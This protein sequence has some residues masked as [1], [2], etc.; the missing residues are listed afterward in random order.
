MVVVGVFPLTLFISVPFVVAADEVVRFNFLT[1]AGREGGFE[2][3]W[4]NAEALAERAAARFF[5]RS[6]FAK[7]LFKSVMLTKGLVGFRGSCC[8]EVV[9]LGKICC[10]SPSLQC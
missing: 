10:S 8:E 4:D 9:A 6:F 5:L 3:G 7:K 1:S 2:S